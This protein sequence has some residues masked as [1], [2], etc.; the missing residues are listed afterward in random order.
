MKAF[1]GS[2]YLV[3]MWSLYKVTVPENLR[4]SP[5][6]E[7]R[8]TRTLSADLGRD[9]EVPVGG[10]FR[11]GFYLGITA[12]GLFKYNASETETGT[13]EGQPPP[14]ERVLPR[15]I[16]G[17]NVTRTHTIIGLF[18]R[19][20]DAEACYSEKS[21]TSFDP[22]WAGNTK[23]VLT[24]IGFHHPLVTISKE[25]KYAVPTNL[26]GIEVPS[27]AETDLTFLDWIRNKHREQSFVDELVWACE[28]DFMNTPKMTQD[29]RSAIYRNHLERIE[30][31]RHEILQMHLHVRT[32]S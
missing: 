29:D 21:E 32:N 11:K 22:G 10:V 15:S 14:F 26:C 1:T 27:E 5:I 12:N 17:N 7:K 25:G 4:S 31:T 2:F 19:Y 6:V 3:T 24:A 9:L 8:A 20:S 30:Q 23:Q 13:V 18:F 28:D 16:C